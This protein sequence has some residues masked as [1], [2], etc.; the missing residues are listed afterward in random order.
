M[1]ENLSSKENGKFIVKRKRKIEF[2]I[3]IFKMHLSTVTNASFL[4]V[5]NAVFMIAGIFLN[6]VV[7]ITLWRSSR[8][9]KKLCY[10]TILVLSCFDLAVMA[11]V[12]PIQISSTISVLL[13]KYNYTQE[14]VRF[15][16]AIAVNSFSMFALLVLNIE[17]F[18]PLTFPYFHQTS[19]RK[20]RLIF[21]LVA[22]II[23][24]TFVLSLSY[25]NMNMAVSL[26]ILTVTVIPIFLLLLSFLNYK[27]FIIARSRRENEIVPSNRL[28]NRP[29]FLFKRV[30]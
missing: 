7:I 28:R 2:R 18:L 4:C 8:L 5:L 3:R 1:A 24:R 23:S 16:V 10:F 29:T 6:S 9:R 21:Y 14:V 26:N 13:E 15:Y 20:R 12:H 25:L 11:I 22:L 17:R 30:H 27:M 19:V